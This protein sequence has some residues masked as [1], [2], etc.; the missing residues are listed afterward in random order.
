MY[1]RKHY[2]FNLQTNLFEAIYYVKRLAVRKHATRHRPARKR[3]PVPGTK[4]IITM[5]SVRKRT[6]ILKSVRKSINQEAICARKYFN[7]QIY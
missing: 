1:V 2:Y 5:P 3:I 7:I 6:N 4:R